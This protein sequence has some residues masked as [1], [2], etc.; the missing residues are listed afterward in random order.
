[1]LVHIVYVPDAQRRNP[2]L[3]RMGK[4]EELPDELGRMMLADG[5][6]REPTDEER[7]DWEATREGGGPRGETAP[8]EAGSPQVVDVPLPD[9]AGGED[10]PAA[11][12]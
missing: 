1:M 2:D 11:E 12:Q 7:A 4:V 8:A 10:V 6:G 3:T 5:T 9:D